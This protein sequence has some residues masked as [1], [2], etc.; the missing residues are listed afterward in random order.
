MQKIVERYETKLSE[1]QKQIDTLVLTNDAQTEDNE[2]LNNDL[3]DLTELH[4]ME[5][6]S[7]KTDLK[8]LEDRLLYK[9]TDYWNELLEKLDKLDTRVSYVRIS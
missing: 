1:M 7:M 8:N 4:Q 6:L 9:F 5:M 3:T 2:R